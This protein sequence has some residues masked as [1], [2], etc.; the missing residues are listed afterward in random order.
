MGQMSR[1][2][3]WA[4]EIQG[5]MVYCSGGKHKVLAGWRQLTMH[6]KFSW[7]C[8]AQQFQY[9]KTKEPKRGSFKS[10]KRHWALKYSWFKHACRLTKPFNLKKTPPSPFSY[11]MGCFHSLKLSLGKWTLLI[12]SA[13]SVPWGFLSLH[14]I[15][16]IK[17][18]RSIIVKHYF[19]LLHSFLF[20]HAQFYIW[21]H[22]LLRNWKHHNNPV[23]L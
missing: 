3:G 4:K 20:P 19:H 7:V 21:R 2:L 17:I 10:N 11:V 12:L 15:T 14:L 1:W 13:A 22:V 23:S 5:G 9:I 18:K 6:P 16:L 8:R